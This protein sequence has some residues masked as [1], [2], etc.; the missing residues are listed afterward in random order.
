MRR[1]EGE[2]GG[3]GRVVE[4]VVGVF[5]GGEERG[6]VLW[7][8]GEQALLLEG[9]DGLEGGE[10]TAG[11]RGETRFLLGGLLGRH[12]LLLL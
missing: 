11:L 1:E 3:G 12:L 7:E 6:E 4:V 9:V 2:K 5:G 8:G 10:L